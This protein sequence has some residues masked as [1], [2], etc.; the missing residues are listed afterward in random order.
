MRPDIFSFSVTSMGEIGLMS[1]FNCFFQGITP[2]SGDTDA[3]VAHDRFRDTYQWYV[4]KFGRDSYNGLSGPVDT[5]VHGKFVDADGKTYLNAHYLPS[6]GVFEFSTGM[7]V[8]D[9]VTHE[10]THAVTRFRSGLKY[11]GYPGALN[12]S[13]SD[14]MAFLHTGDPVL[15]EASAKG[16][17]RD[18]SKPQRTDLRDFSYGDIGPDFQYE[19]NGGVHSNS[20]ITNGIAWKITRDPVTGIGDERAAQLYY[21]AL[22]LHPPSADF[23]NHRFALETAAVML[24]FSSGEVCNIGREFTNALIGLTAHPATA[25]S[26]TGRRRRWRDRYLRQLPHDS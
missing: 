15:G 22:A 16:A 18:V 4:N 19:D 25:N 6:C 14:I 12:E 13:Y 5:A 26:Q 7:L 9:I 3:A 20:G 23:D 21:A 2:D 11:F 10:F 17:I 1:D 24:G 8:D